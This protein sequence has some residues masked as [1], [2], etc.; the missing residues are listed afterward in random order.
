M[1]HNKAFQLLRFVF[2]LMDTSC[3]HRTHVQELRATLWVDNVIYSINIQ[4]NSK[5]TLLDMVQAERDDKVINRDLLKN[6]LKMLMDLGH[7]VY[8]KMFE[9]PFTDLSSS[10][11]RVES[12]E[13]IECY[14][15]G[16]YLK[17]T[18]KCLNE[19]IERV[20]TAWMWNIS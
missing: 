18:E 2:M 13:L 9:K 14:D 19:E 5:F 20:S 12:Q 3:T 11:Y 16:E 8:Q 1:E 6:I 7:S 15:C 4:R 10:L 17:I